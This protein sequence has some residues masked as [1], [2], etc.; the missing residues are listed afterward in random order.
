M[1]E[2]RVATKTVEE[3]SSALEGEVLLA[4]DP[5][6][7]DARTIFNAMIDKRPAAIAQCA[8]V[9]DVALAVRFGRDHGLEIAVR[10]GGHDVAGKSLT[11]GGLVIDLRRMNAVSVDPETHTATVAGGATMSHLDRATEP[12]GL[13][14][15]GGRVSTTGIGGLVLGGG[16]GW[17]DRKFGLMCD[18]LMEIE[19]V[20]AEGEHLRA[21]DDENPELFW[22]LHGGGGNFGVATSFTFR[23]H[24]LRS[25]TTAVLMWDSAFGYD[26]IR[27]YRDFIASAPDEVGGA[28]MF[29][30]A[31]DVDW[32]PESL[33]GTLACTALITY[34]GDKEEARDVIQPMLELGHAGQ[35]I[36]EVPYADLQSMFEDPPGYRNYWSAEYLDAIPD[37]S[38]NLFC[39]RANDMIVPSPS[40]QTLVPLGGAVA[41]AP[42]DYP[43]PWRHAPWHVFPVGMWTDP[44]CD[45]RVRTWTRDLRDDMRP[46]ASGTVYLNFIGEEGYDRVVAGFGRENYQRLASVKAHYDP[47]N[48]FRLNH[49]VKPA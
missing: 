1:T 16:S 28:I 11:D 44:S 2:L 10:G 15:T 4:A 3:F 38:I 12:H 17:L 8:G 18:N 25:V 7:D 22:A 14:T 32:V 48:I 47:D 27:A 37:P 30:T 29:H 39:S 31:P 49:N 23:L 26:V 46:W 20:S 36:F 6:Y 24:P 34:T 43:I 35:V 13:A 33:I 41:R 21:A 40:A 45:A 42:S 9:E 19:L 5:A